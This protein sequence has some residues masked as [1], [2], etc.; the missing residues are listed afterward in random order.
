MS[1]K[2]GYKPIPRISTRVINETRHVSFC[3]KCHSSMIRKYWIY[4]FGGT[5]C[6]NK[7]CGYEKSI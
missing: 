2:G 4:F 5:R 7:E 1:N 6:I 3:P